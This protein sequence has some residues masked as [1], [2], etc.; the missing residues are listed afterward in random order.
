MRIDGN[1]SQNCVKLFQKFTMKFMIM[2]RLVRV[3]AG[4]RNSTLLVAIRLRR[5]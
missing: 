4:L 3:A 5:V 2:I 1:F